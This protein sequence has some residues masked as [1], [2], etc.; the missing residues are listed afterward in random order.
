MPRETTKGII[1]AR[2]LYTLESKFQLNQNQ[3]G[4]RSKR[5]TTDQVLKLVQSAINRFQQNKGETLT[6]AA[7]FDYE[8]AFDKVWRYGVLYKMI[9]LDIPMKFIHYTRSFLSTRQTKV[10][11]K[12]KR[13]NNFYPHQRL[14]QGSAISPLL[15]LIF[16]ND[17][18]SELHPTTIASLFADD[19]SAWTQG[20]NAD[21]EL[22]AERMQEEVDK[23]AKWAETW[24]MSINADKTRALV[25]STNPAG[26]S[27][28]PQLIVN[29]EPIK[30]TKEYKFLGVTV[31]SGLHFNTHIDNIA[32]KGTKRV[33][34]IK[35]LAGKEWGQQLET[36]RKIYL[37]YIHSG[38]ENAS[39]SWWPCIS[40]TNKDK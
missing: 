24:K 17:I 26:H 2:I 35:C 7:F 21:K 31:D 16:I 15:F 1:A 23:I 33:N 34:I 36:Q 18:D 12:N 30:T 29:S 32:T 40:Q 3:A 4:F 38:M 25:L 8:K 5:S 11:V 13:S 28:D 10:E 37:T 20:N 22:T 27:W 19:T 6:I 39:P 14:P 9:K